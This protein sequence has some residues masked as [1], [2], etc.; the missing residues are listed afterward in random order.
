MAAIKSPRERLKDWVSRYP[1]QT[2]AG[3]VLGI[4][5]G[6]VSAILRGSKVPSLDAAAAI[7]RATKGKIRAIEW[8]RRTRKRSAPNVK[9]VASAVGSAS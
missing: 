6:H 9:A 7:E 2:D 1:T 5:Q 8:A 4:S 3:K